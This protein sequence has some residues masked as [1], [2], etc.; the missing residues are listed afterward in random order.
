MKYQTSVA[1]FELPRPP[2]LDVEIC[3]YGDF[4]KGGGFS[5]G[6]ADVVGGAVAEGPTPAMGGPVCLRARFAAG[7]G[8]FGP[9]GRL[10]GFV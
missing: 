4:V 10:F 1:M 3:S 5:A 7:A 6:G 8:A 2:L 9:L